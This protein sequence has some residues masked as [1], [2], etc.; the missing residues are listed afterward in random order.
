M[1]VLYD[2]I[3]HLQDTYEAINLPPRNFNISAKLISNIQ[4][5]PLHVFHT[6]LVYN[7]SHYSVIWIDQS[8]H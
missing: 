4:K 5:I 6:K 3:E 2:F 1:V 7:R 8:Y